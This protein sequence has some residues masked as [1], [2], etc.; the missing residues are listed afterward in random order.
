MDWAAGNAYVWLY[1]Y[2]GIIAENCFRSRAPKF[3]SRIKKKLQ[4]MEKKI[5]GKTVNEESFMILG[6]LVHIVCGIYKWF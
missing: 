1:Y 3:A 6:L 5:V 4:E 2:T